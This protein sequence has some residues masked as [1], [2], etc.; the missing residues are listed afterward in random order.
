[1][2]ILEVLDAAE[3]SA[4]IANGIATKIGKSITCCTTSLICG[5]LIGLIVDIIVVIIL[6]INASSDCEHECDQLYSACN[7]ACRYDSTSTECFAKCFEEC[8]D[9]DPGYYEIMASMFLAVFC[10]ERVSMLIIVPI[11][12]CSCCKKFLQNITDNNE[13]KNMCMKVS[14][15]NLTEFLVKII[16]YRRLLRKVEYCDAAQFVISFILLCIL[17][18]EMWICVIVFMAVWDPVGM[19]GS[20]VSRNNSILD[21]LPICSFLFTAAG[22]VQQMI[23]MGKWMD[24]RCCYFCCFIGVGG[25]LATLILGTIFIALGGR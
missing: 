20:E 10:I 24:Q 17:T 23:M 5:K 3:C 21:G 13:V 8:S 14:S 1:M 18:L 4:N 2:E 12:H 25:S 19:Y 9:C 22:I 11:M 15:F 16:E 7:A 6:Y